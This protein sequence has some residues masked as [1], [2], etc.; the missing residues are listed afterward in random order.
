MGTGIGKPGTVECGASSGEKGREA[1]RW[2]LVLTT[3]SDGCESDRCTSTLKRH[4]LVLLVL[5]YFG[6][7]GRKCYIT[8]LFSFV[9]ISFVEGV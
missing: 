7:R 9:E 5:V 2:L 4:I 8:L 1:T 6:T 3:R